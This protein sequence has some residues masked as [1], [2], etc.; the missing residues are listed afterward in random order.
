[1]RPAVEPG[2]HQMGGTFIEV[3][4]GEFVHHEETGTRL[5]ARSASLAGDFWISCSIS[6]HLSN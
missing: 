4:S 1:M 6:I 3:F 2:R 5:H